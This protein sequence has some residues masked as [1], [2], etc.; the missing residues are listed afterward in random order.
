MKEDQ[1]QAVLDRTLRELHILI[2]VIELHS[3]R[4]TDTHVS[5]LQSIEQEAGR[6]AFRV[7]VRRR[8]GL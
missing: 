8:F 1:S 7:A 6:I 4:L 5:L 2:G 3:D